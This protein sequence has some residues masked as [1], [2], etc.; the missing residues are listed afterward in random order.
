MYEGLTVRAVI[1]ARDEADNIGAV[2]AGLVEL[3]TDTGRRIIDRC[4]R[5]RQ[6][7]RRTPRRTGSVPAWLSSRSLATGRAAPRKRHNQ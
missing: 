2:V 4:R 5:V 6:L 7:A 3:L 1:P